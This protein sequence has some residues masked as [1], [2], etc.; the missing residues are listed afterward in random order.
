MTA[1][2]ALQ[3]ARLLVEQNAVFIHR[4][5]MSSG[6]DW[7]IASILATTRNTKQV[8]TITKVFTNDEWRFKGCAERLTHEVCRQ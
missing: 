5:R 8:T 7:S 2:H 6:E 4:A 1:S 3:E